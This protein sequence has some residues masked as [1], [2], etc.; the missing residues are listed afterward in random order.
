MENRLEVRR[1]NRRNRFNI[2]SGLLLMFAVLI[3]PEGHPSYVALETWGNLEVPLFVWPTLLL[4]SALMVMFAK[5]LRLQVLAFA[6]AALMFF[7]M[8]AGVW[9]SAGPA[10]GSGGC[11]TAMLGCLRIALDIKADAQQ[12]SRMRKRGAA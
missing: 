2:A 1:V 5:P 6:F 4:L 12:E 8:G 3:W 10:I 9:L 7:L 11:L